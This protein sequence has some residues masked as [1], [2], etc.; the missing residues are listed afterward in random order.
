VVLCQERKGL[1][2]LLRRNVFPPQMAR[3]PRQLIS[4]VNARTSDEIKG[5]PSNAYISLRYIIYPPPARTWRSRWSAQRLFGSGTRRM[6]CLQVSYRV[7]SVLCSSLHIVLNTYLF[8]PKLILPQLASAG[9]SGL[10]MISSVKKW[11]ILLS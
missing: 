1:A 8:Y 9:D 4:N 2:R 10:S 11:Q 3:A 5:K 7:V 6:L